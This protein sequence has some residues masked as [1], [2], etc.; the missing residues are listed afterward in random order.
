M[1]STCVNV[2][3]LMLCLLATAATI[4][5]KFISVDWWGE[6]NSDEVTIIWSPFGSKEP[7]SGYRIRWWKQGS[8]VSVI[9]ITGVKTT[10]ITFLT[11]LRAILK[12]AKAAKWTVDF[13]VSYNFFKMIPPKVAQLTVLYK[14]VQ[15]YR[16]W[17]WKNKFSHV[18]CWH[19]T[20]M[21]VWE[22]AAYW[23]LR[24]FS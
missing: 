3:R 24:R 13:W 22:N 2:T 16:L 11:K 1:A 20:K 10:L 8:P 15:Y 18:S 14:N 7:G 5:R 6:I 19:W 4:L 23:D 9:Q 12:I 17:T 21:A